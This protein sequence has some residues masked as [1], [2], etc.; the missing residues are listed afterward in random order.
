[1]HEIDH[2]FTGF[3]RG[4]NVVDWIERTGIGLAGARQIIT[5][6]GGRLSVESQE[7]SGSTFTVRLPLATSE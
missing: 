7:G 6:H 2:I 3:Y 5:Q 4:R 1:M